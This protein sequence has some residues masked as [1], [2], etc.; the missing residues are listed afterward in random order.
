MQISLREFYAG[1]IWLSTVPAGIFL[2]IHQ[3]SLIP[4]CGEE[5]SAFPPLRG[6]FWNPWNT[7]VPALF[8]EMDHFDLVWTTIPVIM[9]T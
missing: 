6:F 1:F 3:D 4:V 8:P 7:S 2:S 5:P 9:L